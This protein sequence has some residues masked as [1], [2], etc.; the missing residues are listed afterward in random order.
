MLQL[1]NET[2]DITPS[3]KW[4]E[5]KKIIEKD[6]RFA[7]FNISERVLFLSFYLFT[8]FYLFNFRI[9]GLF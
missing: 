2:K 6:E 9:F 1:L 3:M 7:K 4:R 8:T 5:A